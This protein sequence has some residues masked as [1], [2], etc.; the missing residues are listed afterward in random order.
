MTPTKMTPEKAMEMSRS[1]ET[2]FNRA[3]YMARVVQDERYQFRGGADPWK[4]DL[5][6]ARKRSGETGESHTNTRLLVSE[7]LECA[8]AATEWA[9]ALN[10]GGTEYSMLVGRFRRLYAYG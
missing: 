7:E 2:E 3:L 10:E 1:A 8:L 5:E 4:I 6:A 9:M